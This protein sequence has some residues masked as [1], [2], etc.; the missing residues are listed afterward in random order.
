M[1]RSLLHQILVLSLASSA[2]ACSGDD[3]ETDAGAV[4]A[5]VDGGVADTGSTDTGTVDTG[6]VDTGIVPDAGTP[7]TG[8]GGDNNDGFD[9]AFD[10]RKNTNNGFR[11]A[12]AD[13]G[14]RD[15]YFFEGTA[16]EFVRVFTNSA[17]AANGDRVDTVI[18]LYD[19]AEVQVAENDDAVPRVS[20]DSE[21]IYRL[22]ADGRYYIEVI[23]WSDWAEEALKGQANYAYQL[24]VRTVNANNAGTTIEAEAGNDAASAIPAILSQN[25]GLLCGTFEDANDIDVYAFNQPAEGYLYFETMPAGTDA[26]GAT[27]PVGEVWLTDTT[28]MDIKARLDMSGDTTNF[29]PAVAAGDYLLWVKH[30]GTAAGSNDFYAI[31]PLILT[32]ND[33]EVEPNDSRATAE[34][35]ALTARA[36][37]MD[38][39]NFVLANLPDGDVDYFR[40]EPLGNETLTVVCGSATA[41]SGVQ[42]LNV[43]LQDDNGTVLAMASEP[44]DDLA[45][46]TDQ[47]VTSSVV[48]VKVAKTGQD[49]MIS[50]DYVRCG[51]FANP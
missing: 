7:D 15:Y 47:T 29:S 36:D 14:D 21:I 28:G 11:A 32:G 45:R 6:T 40:L 51:F 3:A 43:E 2:F 35:R 38:R 48:Y 13:P 49:S 16:G 50:G 30:P 18:R 12:I 20:V 24:L 25:A 42:G 39:A 27:N 22:P 1:S 41:G 17:A 23:E 46:I 34:L 44:V 10:V 4:D 19:S 37:Q 26:H 5:A 31:K 9:E 8:P 33:P